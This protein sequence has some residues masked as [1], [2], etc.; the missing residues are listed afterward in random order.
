MA[1]K[2]TTAELR[3]ELE[4]KKQLAETQEELNQVTLETLE[5]NLRAS[6]ENKDTTQTVF[7]HA[8]ALKRFKEETEGLKAAQD[9]LRS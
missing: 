3:A 2:K 8:E 9:Q 1:E 4:I 6:K 7:R 5:L